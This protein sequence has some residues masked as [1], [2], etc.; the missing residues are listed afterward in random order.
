MLRR[1]ILVA[2]ASLLLAGCESQFIKE[3]MLVGEYRAEESEEVRLI[4][5]ADRTYLM[6]TSASETNVGQW[7]MSWAFGD[8]YIDMNDTKGSHATY[9]V[10]LRLFGESSIVLDAQNRTLVK[11]A[12]A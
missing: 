12:D 6:R 5:N 9:D 3:E 11:V 8:V 2:C 10:R 4:L 7:H 1:S